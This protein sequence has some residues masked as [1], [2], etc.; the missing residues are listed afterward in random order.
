VTRDTDDF[1]KALT[2]VFNPWIDPL[3]VAAVKTKK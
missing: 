2:A 1:V 3:L